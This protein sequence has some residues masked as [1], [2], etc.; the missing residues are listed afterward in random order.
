VISSL[1][2]RR[3]RAAEFKKFLTRIDIQVLDNMQVHRIADNYAAHKS[4][5]I[6]GLN[7]QVACTLSGHL[8]WVLVPGLERTHFGGHGT[9]LAC[10]QLVGESHY[11][12][13]PSSFHG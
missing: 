5:T 8:A 6:T 10:S 1:H 13:D 2:R 9:K 4:P 12:I 11:G 7:V 3:R